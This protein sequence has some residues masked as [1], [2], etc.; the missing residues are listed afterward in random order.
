MKKND[1]LDRSLD[2]IR[3]HPNAANLDVP[4]TLVEK[5][6]YDDDPDDTR[7]T[8]FYLTVFSFGYFQHELMKSDL[9]TGQ[10]H[11]VASARL[12]ECFAAWQMKLA[13]AMIHRKTDL[14][15]APLP[16]FDFPADEQI[17][18]WPKTPSPLR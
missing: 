1:I 6:I 13:L 8:G 17:S 5:W 3:S 9:P 11:K 14:N 7:P 18:Y 4:D 12:F 2:W 10:M 15:V 16:L